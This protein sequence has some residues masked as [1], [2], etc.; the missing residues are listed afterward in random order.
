V[1]PKTVSGVLPAHFLFHQAILLNFQNRP[2]G[3]YYLE[4]IEEKKINLSIGYLQIQGRLNICFLKETRYIHRGSSIKYIHTQLYAVIGFMHLALD[5]GD[6]H[7][8]QLLSF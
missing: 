4:Q 2:G 3:H 1:V 7:I 8:T 6:S 5:L